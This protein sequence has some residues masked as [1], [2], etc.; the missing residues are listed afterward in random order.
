MA[1]VPIILMFHTIDLRIG[2]EGLGSECERQFGVR[3]ECAEYIY[4]IMYDSATCENHT[5]LLCQ[6]NCAVPDFSIGIAWSIVPT[7]EIW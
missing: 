7:K 5:T 6:I 3:P 2:H 1:Y 4:A